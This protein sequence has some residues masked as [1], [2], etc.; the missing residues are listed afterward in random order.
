MLGVEIL[1]VGFENSFRL[2]YSDDDFEVLP[3]VQC[4]MEMPGEVDVIRVGCVYIPC[5]LYFLSG[6][7]AKFRG[8]V[9]AGLGAWYF[10]KFRFPL[11]AACD[12]P[13]K[14]LFLS[15]LY[16]FRALRFFEGVRE[17]KI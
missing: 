13:I 10:C 7:Y 3:T 8:Y 14:L 1:H 16:R 17:A 11:F 9:Y 6:V 5:I 12:W 15:L 4:V 2:C